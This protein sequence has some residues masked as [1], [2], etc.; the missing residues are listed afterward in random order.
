VIFFGCG[1]ATLRYLGSRS[2]HRAKIRVDL[3]PNFLDFRKKESLIPWFRLTPLREG[4]EFLRGVFALQAHPTRQKA[5]SPFE[6][7][8]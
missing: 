4:S 6:D 5:P 7:G 2:S 8:A 3:N 1:C